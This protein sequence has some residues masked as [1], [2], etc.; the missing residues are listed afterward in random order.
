MTVGQ[1][2]NFR[3]FGLDSPAVVSISHTTLAA[4]AGVYWIPW[5]RSPIK[6]LDGLPWWTSS[7]PPM[8]KSSRTC[9]LFQDLPR[10]C[11]DHFGSLWIILV[12]CVRVGTPSRHCLE[13]CEVQ[14]HICSGNDRRIGH[15]K[16]SHRPTCQ[17]HLLGA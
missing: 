7:A 4:L 3:H 9:I 10:V 11:L 8:P 13:I 17:G 14:M 1:P 15:R 6:P 16:Q 2:S 12:P 5:R